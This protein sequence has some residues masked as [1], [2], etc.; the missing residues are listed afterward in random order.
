MYRIL[1]SIFKI[2][3]DTV[4]SILGLIANK[5]NE[6]DEEEDDSTDSPKLFNNFNISSFNVSFNAGNNSNKK[7][8][9][10]SKED[11]KKKRTT[12]LQRRVNKTI[13]SRSDS[14]S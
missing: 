7:I 2:D 9:P 10:K 3:S 14:Y 6:N 12:V 8:D 11:T 5:E 4:E 13:D 1:K